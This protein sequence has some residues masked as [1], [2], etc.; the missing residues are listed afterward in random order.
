MNDF[1]AIGT[2]GFPRTLGFTLLCDPEILVPQKNPNKLSRWGLASP[3]TPRIG[4]IS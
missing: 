4:R 3:P 2:G 1:S